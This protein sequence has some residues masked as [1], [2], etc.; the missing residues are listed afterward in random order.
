MFSLCMCWFPSNPL[1]H[2]HSIIPIPAQ[3][4]SSIYPARPF[5]HP[6]VKRRLAAL[7]TEE[8]LK[9]GVK[10]RDVTVDDAAVSATAAATVAAAELVK[11][12]KLK[13]GG[14][15]ENYTVFFHMLM[16]VCVEGLWGGECGVFRGLS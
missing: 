2:A 14:V 3:S 7:H 5:S 16:Q 4:D 1:S 11:A 12:E 6:Q 15:A 13:D 10:K 8:Q 9:A